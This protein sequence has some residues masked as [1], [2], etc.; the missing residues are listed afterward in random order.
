MDQGLIDIGILVRPFDARKFDYVPIGP[1]ARWGL[2]V[3]TDDPLAGHEKILPSDLRGRKLCLPGRK[4]LSPGRQ[5]RA[6]CCCN[7]NSESIQ[8]WP[9]NGPYPKTGR[10]QHSSSF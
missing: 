3:R 2:Y 1:E 5:L 9:G 4:Q 8:S 7:R 10:S 6:L